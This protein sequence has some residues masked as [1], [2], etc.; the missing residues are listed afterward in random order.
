[1]KQKYCCSFL[2]FFFGWGAGGPRTT[3]LVEANISVIATQALTHP[4][5]LYSYKLIFMEQN[6]WK[7]GRGRRGKFEIVS[8]KGYR[9]P[10]SKMILCGQLPEKDKWGRRKVDMTR[11]NQGLQPINQNKISLVVK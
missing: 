4:Q 3:Q 5:G 11:A 7:D 10:D 1:M 9:I 2:F 6:I 8:S